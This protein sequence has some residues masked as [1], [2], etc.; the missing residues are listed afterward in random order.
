MLLNRINNKI[1]DYLNSKDINYDL[2]FL[3]SYNNCFDAVLESIKALKSFRK[4][5]DENNFSNIMEE[6]LKDLD[7]LNNS[8]TDESIYIFSSNWLVSNDSI[9]ISICVDKIELYLCEY[10]DGE[11]EMIN[12]FKNFL[13]IYYANFLNLTSEDIENIENIINEVMKKD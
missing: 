7:V 10:S 13:L 9:D 3:K 6:L 4:E 12:K 5:I 11:E 8:A 2:Y 1:S